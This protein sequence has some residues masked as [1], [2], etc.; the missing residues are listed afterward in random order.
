VP[1]HLYSSAGH[2]TKGQSGMCRDKEINDLC[3]TGL[4][5]GSEMQEAGVHWACTSDGGRK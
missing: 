5:E 3:R 4:R 1:R 2:G